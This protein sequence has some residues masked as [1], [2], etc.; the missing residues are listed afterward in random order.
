MLFRSRFGRVLIGGVRVR[1]ERDQCDGAQSADKMF[2]RLSSNGGDA[3]PARLESLF[4]VACGVAIMHESARQNEAYDALSR[5]SF[6]QAL[7]CATIGSV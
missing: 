1:G 5:V 7:F 2:H 6:R 4:A 3:D